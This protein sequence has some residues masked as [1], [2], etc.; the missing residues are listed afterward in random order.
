MTMSWFIICR[1]PGA[2]GHKRGTDHTSL[3]GERHRVQNTSMNEIELWG[4]NNARFAKEGITSA[5]NSGA[6]KS[7]LGTDHLTR[8]WLDT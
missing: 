8:I 3:V 6:N 4:F 2:F 1:S 5:L 7:P